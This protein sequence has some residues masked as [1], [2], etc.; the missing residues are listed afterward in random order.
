VIGCFSC[1]ITKEKILSENVLYVT[2]RFCVS[3]GPAGHE[4]MSPDGVVCAISAGP[5][6]HETRILYSDIT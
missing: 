2:E 5:A 4:T 1:D 6:G 3:A